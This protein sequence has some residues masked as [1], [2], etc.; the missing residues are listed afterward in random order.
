[1]NYI[2][3]NKIVFS[4]FANSYF[5]IRNKQNDTIYIGKANGIEYGIP[6]VSQYPIVTILFDNLITILK[7]K[8][9]GYPFDE[10]VVR[11]FECVLEIDYN[12]RVE[13]D[14]GDYYL[15]FEDFLEIEILTGEE[16]S[17]IIEKILPRVSTTHK[18][19]THRHTYAIGDMSLQQC[20][21]NN[22]KYS[23]KDGVWLYVDESN[24]EEH[25]QDMTTENNNTMG[26]HTRE[27]Q[28]GEFG[29]FSKIK[30]E[31]EELEDAYN[32]NDK[33]LQ[34]CELTDLVGAIKEYI[35]KFNLTLEDLDHFAIK[36][37]RAF[38]EGKR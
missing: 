4:A 37:S 2:E 11:D 9:N 36:T 14:T 28:K 27:I 24:N 18:N 5:R 21:I 26:Y 16:Y 15:Q 31:F 17:K 22:L 20:K 10:R 7:E 38:K 3:Y 32:Q 8:G 25:K 13:T 6:R 1:M 29:E 23:Y 33:I 34:I 19:K 12:P 35:K 30:E